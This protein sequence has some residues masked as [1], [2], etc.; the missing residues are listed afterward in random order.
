MPELFEAKSNFVNRH[1]AIS[2]QG[3]SGNPGEY[4]EYTYIVCSPWL[5]RLGNNWPTFISS[6]G[7]AL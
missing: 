3:R 7:P 5:D 2:A 4:G 6:Y 1:T